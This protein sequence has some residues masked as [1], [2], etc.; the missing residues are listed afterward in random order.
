MNTIQ[1]QQ[2]NLF[3]YQDIL[4]S[5]EDLSYNTQKVVRKQFVCFLIL[6]YFEIYQQQEIPSF[7]ELWNICF[8]QQTQT[9]KKLTKYDK[10]VQQKVTKRKYIKKSTYKNT[11]PITSNVLNEQTFHSYP[12]NFQTHNNLDQPLTNLSKRENNNSQ[13]DLNYVQHEINN[14]IFEEESYEKDCM[15]CF[16]QFNNNQTL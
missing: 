2:S 4:K 6:R 7:Y 9:K 14:R 11:S 8:P 16:L 5:E 1:Q 12:L 3:K 15:S 10:K 13:S